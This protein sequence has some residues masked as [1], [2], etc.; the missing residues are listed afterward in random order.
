MNSGDLKAILKLMYMKNKEFAKMINVRQE[1]VSRWRKGKHPIPSTV[2]LL[3]QKELA[4]RGLEY[5]CEGYQ[6]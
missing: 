4:E 1:T 6:P 5:E 2:Q 3:L